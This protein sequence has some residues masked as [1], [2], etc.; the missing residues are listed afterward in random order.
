MNVEFAAEVNNIQVGSIS[1]IE[2][3]AFKAFNEGTRLK[4]YIRLQPHRSNT[5]HFKG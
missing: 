2:H 1:F 3:L 4:D 5:T